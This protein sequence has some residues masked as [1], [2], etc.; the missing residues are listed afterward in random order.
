MTIKSSQQVPREVAEKINPLISVDVTSTLISCNEVISVINDLHTL[1]MDG[2][3]M[4]HQA[5]REVMK[6]VHGAIEYEISQDS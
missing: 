3:D 5:V 1:A 4:S 2:D 6:C